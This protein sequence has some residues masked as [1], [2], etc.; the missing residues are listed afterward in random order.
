M[1]KLQGELFE[2]IR[3]VPQH[4]RK[5]TRGYKCV[6]CGAGKLSTIV[7]VPLCQE[8]APPIGEEESYLMASCGLRRAG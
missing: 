3:R 1:P 2:D 5:Y 6:R 4:F 7:P 8:C